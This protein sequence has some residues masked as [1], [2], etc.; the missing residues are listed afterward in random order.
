MV[1]PVWIGGT[2]HAGHG[3][4]EPVVDARS[5]VGRSKRCQNTGSLRLVTWTLRKQRESFR[6]AVP[7][8]RPMRMPNRVDEPASKVRLSVWLV[9]TQTFA[10][11]SPTR[12]L[13][14]RGAAGNPCAGASARVGGCDDGDPKTSLQLTVRYDRVISKSGTPALVEGAPVVVERP[15]PC[16][17]AQA[18]KRRQL[19]D[20]RTVRANVLHALTRQDPSALRQQGFH[21]AGCVHARYCSSR[22]ETK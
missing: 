20:S 1:S 21:P 2:S 10:A 6:S 18:A 15:P 8:L 14:P 13:L 4:A 5:V 12:L 16:H 11:S 22:Q 17:R 3:R 9:F 19:R 7:S